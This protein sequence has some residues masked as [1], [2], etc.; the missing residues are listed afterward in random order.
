MVDEYFYDV[1]FYARLGA[2]VVVVSDWT[3]PELPRHDNWRKELHDAARFDPA[4]G[5]QV[6]WPSA[7]LDALGCGGG[8]VWFVLKPGT[9]AR[10]LAPLAGAAPAY[11]DARTELW[12]APRHACR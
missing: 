12:R 6:L 11:S 2:P 8:E 1:P 3:D 5:S 10:L 4:R 7:R 9:G